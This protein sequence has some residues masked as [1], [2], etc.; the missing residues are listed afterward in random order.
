MF[1]EDA[2]NLTKIRASS[3]K[4]LPKRKGRPHNGRPARLDN[5]DFWEV[6]VIRAKI[7]TFSGKLS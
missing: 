5:H 4:V 7:P 3:G 6:V 2:G 1:G